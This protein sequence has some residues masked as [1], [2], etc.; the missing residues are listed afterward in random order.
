VIYR[1]ICHKSGES[2]Q[3]RDKAVKK[4]KSSKGLLP[5]SKRPK[6]SGEIGDEIKELDKDT[7]LQ[8]IDYMNYSVEICDTSLCITYAAERM[9]GNMIYLKNC[10][11]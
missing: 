10:H 8:G 1:N 11:W 2:S 5:K 3:Y 4:V 6:N 7:I 9:K